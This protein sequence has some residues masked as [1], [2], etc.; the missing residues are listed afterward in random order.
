MFL[1]VIDDVINHLLKARVLTGSLLERRFQSSRLQYPR[2]TDPGVNPPRAVGKFPG[3]TITPWW[4]GERV[5]LVLFFNF[6]FLPKL[7]V[8]NLLWQ[9]SQRDKLESATCLKWILEFCGSVGFDSGLTL[10]SPDTQT[11]FPSSGS[12]LATAII[13]CFSFINSQN[14][15]EIRWPYFDI[16]NTG[17]ISLIQLYFHLCL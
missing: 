15:T 10:F 16:L 5:P 17:K 11:Y 9:P 12:N 2:F 1:Q 3:H 4:W 14:S 6:P 7:L 13:S 8:L